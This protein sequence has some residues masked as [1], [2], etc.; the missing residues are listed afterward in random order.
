MHLFLEDSAVH[1]T[2]RKGGLIVVIPLK[3]FTHPNEKQKRVG[4]PQVDFFLFFKEL[5]VYK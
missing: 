4:P 3:I 2:E 1:G 5:H